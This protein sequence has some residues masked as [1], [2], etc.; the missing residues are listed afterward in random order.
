MKSRVEG[1]IYQNENRYT[2]QFHYL[3]KIFNNV[4]IEH[5]FTKKQLNINH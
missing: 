5:M 3:K 2:K 4:L 1:E